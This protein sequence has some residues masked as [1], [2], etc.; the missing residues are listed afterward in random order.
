M[1]PANEA[2]IY[3][4]IKEAIIQQK[5]RPNMQLVEDVIAESFGVSRTPVRNVLRRLAM[6]KLVTV[7]PYKG[8]FVAC[9][10]IEEAKE[11]FEMRRV[12]E[13]AAIRKIC[14]S[15]TEEQFD[16]LRLLSEEEH[17]MHRQGDFLGVLRISG[18][19]HLKIAEMTGNDYCLRYLEELVSLTYVINAFY[20]KRMTF[21]NDHEQILTAIKQGDEDLAENLMVEHL[22]QIE[23]SLDFDGM[24]VNPKSLGEIFK[25]RETSDL[26]K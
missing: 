25:A 3:R 10:S 21:C 13:S 7:I 14:H 4:E 23:R 12:L 11:V 16:Q 18:D 24:D 17:E 6:E 1:S 19:F 8:T 22:K 15:L 20:G 26:K 2:E 9:P 5:L